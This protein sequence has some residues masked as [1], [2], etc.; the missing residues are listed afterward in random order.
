[1]KILVTG[2]AGFI[3]YHL[4]KR[5]LEEGNEVVGLDNLNEYYSVSLKRA[6]LAE[7]GVVD[8]MLPY[9]RSCFT[10]VHTP[11]CAITPFQG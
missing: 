2:S 11:A 1:M 6:R 4:T 7:L 10:G 3:G 9:R 5:L 8:P